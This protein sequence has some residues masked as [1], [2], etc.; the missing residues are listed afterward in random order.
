MP[1]ISVILPIY[2]VELYLAECIDSIISQTFKDF[3]LLLVD[4]G[5]TDNSLKICEE[6]ASKDVRIKSFH[7][8]NGGLSSARNYGLDRASGCYVM[9]VDPDDYLLSNYT[10]SR[11][12]SYANDKRLDI[13]RFDY[14]AVNDDNSK[15]LR[16]GPVGA[17]QH[18]C[19]KVL[20]PLEMVKDAVR[21]EWFAVLF[22]IKRT[23]LEEM[24][25]DESFK[26]QEDIE[27]FA[28]LFA[29]RDLRC[30]YY[31]ERY[32][33]YRIRQNSITNDFRI[34]RFYYS[35]TLCDVFAD[36]AKSISVNRLKTLYEYNSVMMYYWTLNS[37]SDDPYYGKWK[38]IFDDCEVRAVHSRTLRRIRNVTGI[39]K[40]WLFIIFKPSWAIHLLRIKT[41]IVL[42]LKSVRACLGNCAYLQ[43]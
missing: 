1:L 27:F 42:L 28:R 32:Y 16:L 24:R 13:L 19:N 21:G 8:V 33:A 14:L 4:D 30:G 35:F 37:I 6:Y 43:S 31:P 34:S 38:E 2:N 20:S 5:S 22:L 26:F 25:F 18:L 3:E 11:L 36:L 15:I 7:K 17:K 10:F 9:F 39:C 29:S 41:R 40:Y 12:V 23:A